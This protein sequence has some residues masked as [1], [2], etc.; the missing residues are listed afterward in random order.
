MSM[1]FATGLVTDQK[2]WRPYV[3]SQIGVRRPSEKIA[4]YAAGMPGMVIKPGTFF[5]FPSHRSMF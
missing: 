5:M 2:N 1:R 3:A 4:S